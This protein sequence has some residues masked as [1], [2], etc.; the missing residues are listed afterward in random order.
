VEA[1]PPEGKSLWQRFVMHK[2]YVDELYE[3]VT[4]KPLLLMSTFFDKIIDR[5]L[6]DGVINLSV[7]GYRY[8]GTL[9]AQLQNG[10]VRYYAL[11]ILAGVALMSIF[12]LIVLEGM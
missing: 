12:I 8:T 3:A 7:F 11:Y 6:F 10:K 2:F 5:L 9:F 1:A 4:V